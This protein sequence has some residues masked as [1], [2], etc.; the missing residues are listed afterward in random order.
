MSDRGG[1]SSESSASP[2]SSA[3]D[4]S[5]GGFHASDVESSVGSD[6]SHLC[7]ISD[8]EGLSESDSEAYHEVPGDQATTERSCEASTLGSEN[9]IFRA[10]ILIVEQPAVDEGEVDQSI[11]DGRSIAH[12]TLNNHLCQY[13]SIN[14]E[15]GGEIAGIAEIV[16]MKLVSTGR[17]LA[18]DKAEDCR[19]GCTF[20]RY[21]Q[22]GCAPEYWDQRI[23]D[24]HGILPTNPRITG[25]DEMH[26][27][28][29]QF[30]SWLAEHSLA[31]QP[32]F[33]VAWNGG[34]C[35]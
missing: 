21:V 31:A 22:P 6:V 32:I 35:D 27:V 17:K 30:L 11:P 8:P 26:I 9:D 7:S 18:S 5:V 16:H 33:L 14:I 28:W 1:S 15:T 3:S 2:S 23:I 20:N 19:R 13:L 34:T 4:L 12:H 10:E 25:A 29:P 24:V